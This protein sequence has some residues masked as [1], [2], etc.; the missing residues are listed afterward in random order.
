M[1][2]FEYS[3]QLVS[4]VAG[5]CDVKAICQAASSNPARYPLLAGVD[6]YDDTTFNPRQAVMLI[7]ELGRLTAA[8]DDPYLSD[9]VAALI[10]LAE[11]LLP[12][13]RRPP[14]RRLVFN[15]D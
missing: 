8:A 14:H 12:A 3:G 13:R 1:R 6:E 4:E 11:L 2:V 7:A 5:E 9:A 15:G 10:T